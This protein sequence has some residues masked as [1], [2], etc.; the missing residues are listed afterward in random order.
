MHVIWDKLEESHNEILNMVRSFCEMVIQQKQ[1]ANVS[2]YTSESSRRYNYKDDDDDEEY[3]IPLKDMPQISPFIA[4]VPVSF[5]MEP[6]DSLSMGDERLSTIPEKESDEFIKSSVEDLVPIPSESEDS[7]RSDSE[8]ILP[9]CEDLSPISIFEE[10][11]MTFSNPL[12]DS[13][14]DFTSSDDES[15]SDEDVP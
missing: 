8:N 7:S 12:F 13:N 1:A 2:T 6:E 14:N 4:L 9:S 10:K 3:S 5:I 11:S 15:L